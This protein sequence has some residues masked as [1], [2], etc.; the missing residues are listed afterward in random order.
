MNGFPLRENDEGESI[1]TFRHCPNIPVIRQPLRHPP[2]LPS[3]ANHSVIRQPLR[4]PR[5]AGIHFSG[6]CT[7]LQGCRREDDKGSAKRWE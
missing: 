6:R 4:H 1:S 2:A 3:S 7:T 5:G